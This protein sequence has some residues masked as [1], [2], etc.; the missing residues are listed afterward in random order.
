MKKHLIQAFVCT[1]KEDGTG[2]WSNTCWSFDEPAEAQATLDVISK[3]KHLDI[4]KVRLIESLSDEYCFNPIFPKSLNEEKLINVNFNIFKNNKR[5]KPADPKNIVII[6]AFSEFGCEMVGAMYCIPEIIRSSGKYVIVVGWYGREYLYRH[7]ADEFW[8]L[9]E[10]YMWMRD[11]AKA[12]HNDS[13]NIKTI[14]NNLNKYG[15]VL[16]SGYLGR[17][18]IGVNCLDCKA[19]WGSKW[20][21]DE[22]VKCKGKNVKQSLFGDVAGNKPNAVKIP[23][24]S[25]EKLEYVKK[26]LGPNPVGI[27]ARN[28]KCYGRNLQVEFYVELIKRLENKGYTPIWLGEK[29]ST[30]PCPVK[31]IYDFSRTDEARDLEL[32]LAIVKQLKFTVQ[33]WTASTR[34]AAIMGVPYILFESPDQIWGIG[35]EGYRLNLCTMGPKKVAIAHYL[36]VFNDNNAG[37]DLFERCVIELEEENYDYVFGCLEDE[38]VARSMQEEHDRRIGGGC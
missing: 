29:Q 34:L 33:F 22:C 11:Y 19:F 36:N 17:T 14:E 30:F 5:I 27:F 21:V 1:N 7:L 13:K 28:R 35:Q 26:Y 12:F 24:P 15:I 6:C 4:P 38:G 18:A 23:A 10:E 8:E 20:H 9:K 25:A 32:T 31:H 16:T 2:Y 3:C 37:L